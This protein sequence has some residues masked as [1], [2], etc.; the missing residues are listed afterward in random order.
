MVSGEIEEFISRHGGKSIECVYNECVAS[1]RKYLKRKNISFLEIEDVVNDVMLHLTIRISEK[2]LTLTCS[3]TTFLHSCCKMRIHE[4][5]RWRKKVKEAEIEYLLHSSEGECPDKLIEYEEKML[6][7][8]ELQSTLRKLGPK[9]REM[10]MLICKGN[11]GNRL[12]S[13]MGFI[14]KQ[15][16]A[17]FKRNCKIKIKEHSNNFKNS[18]GFCDEILGLYCGLSE[19]ESE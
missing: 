11:T 1:L 19:W 8:K 5:C 7:R 18:Q 14:N 4:I 9:R 15:S 6:K 2:N 13:R 17:D 10:F 12:Q 3:F 16:M